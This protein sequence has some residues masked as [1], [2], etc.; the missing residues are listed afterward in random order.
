MVKLLAVARMGIDSID[1]Y[2][3]LGTQ[4]RNEAKKKRKTE[5]LASFRYCNFI[6][7]FSVSGQAPCYFFFTEAG[8]LEFFLFFTL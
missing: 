2:I 5:G 4:K 8:V 1:T 3:H 6:S 7:V